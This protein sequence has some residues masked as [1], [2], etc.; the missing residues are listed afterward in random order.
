MSGSELSQNNAAAREHFGKKVADANKFR[1]VW[2]GYLFERMLHYTLKFCSYS[3]CFNLFKSAL[4]VCMKKTPSLKGCLNGNIV[5]AGMSCL[6]RHARLKQQCGFDN[7][8]K[9][10]Y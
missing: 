7:A 3:N 6:E 5:Y 4:F 9:V 1:V 8:Y 2:E 10:L